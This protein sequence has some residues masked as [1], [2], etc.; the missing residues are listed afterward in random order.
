LDTTGIAVPV[1]YTASPTAPS[2]PKAGD[3]WY[4]TTSDVLYTR[5][6]NITTSFWV[7]FSGQ[8]AVNDI[9]GPDTIIQVSYGGTGKGF[10]TTNALIKGAGTGAFEEAV[11]GTDYIAPSANS[12]ITNY[13]FAGEI[14]RF[15]TYANIS[16]LYTSSII[17]TGTYTGTGMTLEALTV[18]GN[19]IVGNLNT[20]TDIR[21]EGHLI[22][23]NVYAN[24]MISGVNL[25]YSGNISY[26][27]MVVGNV[28]ATNVILGYGPGTTFVDASSSYASYVDTA[29]VD[30]SNFSGMIMVT[31]WGTGITVM[32]LCGGQEATPIGA[33]KYGTGYGTI[34]YNAGINGYTWTNNT[35]GTVEASFAATKTRGAA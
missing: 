35:G 2:A 3:Y 12:V 34:E 24:N 10:F 21:T 7:D 17:N 13:E 8:G 5:V 23:G 26:D 19:I 33:S 9:T 4:D 30:F 6:D 22:A 18:N 15:G 29:T 14:A 1:T 20:A 28:Y 27:N 25:T 16:T 31:I 32:Y 11:A